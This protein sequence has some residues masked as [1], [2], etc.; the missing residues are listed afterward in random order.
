MGLF[1]NIGN[2]IQ[3][4][5]ENIQNLPQNAWN[6]WVNTVGKAGKGFIENY[7]GMN[8]AIN[9][10]NIVT[11]DQGFSYDK[12]NIDS[13]VNYQNSKADRLYNE[14]ALDRYFDAL[15]RNGIN[16]A[17]VLGNSASSAISATTSDSNNSSGGYHIKDQ[18]NSAQKAAS[19]LGS[20]ASLLGAVAALI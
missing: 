18:V 4:T 14:K 6:A 16:P 1:E 8:A 11:D 13:L 20:L 2:S 5:N 17:L 19:A 9:A 15:K 3:Q 7:N 12:T 10:G